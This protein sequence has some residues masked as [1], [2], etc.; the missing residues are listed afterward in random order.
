MIVIAIIVMLLPDILGVFGF[1]SLFKDSVNAVLTL[2]LGALG[3]VFHII[4]L[5]SHKQLSLNALTLLLS[6]GLI[7]A[8]VSLTAFDIPNIHYLTLGG[9]LLI[10]AWIAIPQPQK[11]KKADQS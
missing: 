6:V 2:S 7:I 4:Y 10:A 3:I 8:G 11:N 1:S 9:L 5:A